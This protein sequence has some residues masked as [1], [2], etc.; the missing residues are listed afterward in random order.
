MTNVFPGNWT[1]P[2]DLLTTV[3]FYFAEGGFI[4]KLGK[5]SWNVE[6]FKNSIFNSKLQ[7]KKSCVSDFELNFLK[8]SIFKFP[9]PP[10]KIG[11]G[12][13]SVVTSE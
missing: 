6:F 12:A 7:K 10:G 13:G 11:L 3:C 2:V 5:F 9:C 8:T 1:L 4:H